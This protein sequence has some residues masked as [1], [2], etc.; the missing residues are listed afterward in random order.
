MNRLAA[1]RRFLNA[2]RY[3]YKTV[4]D[5]D[6]S[7]LLQLGVAVLASERTTHWG[8]VGIGLE[9]RPATLPPTAPNRAWLG[10]VAFAPDYWPSDYLAKLLA[11]AAGCFQPLQL[12][13]EI[14]AQSHTGWLEQALLHAGFVCVDQVVSMVRDVS[15]PSPATATPCQLRSALPTDLADVAWLDTA[16][17]TP[18]WHFSEQQLWE[19]LLRGRMQLA[20]YE[21]RL[22]G[23]SALLTNNKSEAQLARLAVHPAMQRRG[24]GRQLLADSLDYARQSGFEHLALNTQVD[25]MRS[26]A[27]YRAFDFFFTGNPI[28]I[29]TKIYYQ[30]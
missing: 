24:I 27:L 9:E 6:L 30:S 1:V 23:Y 12:P 17:F 11:T 28:S 29:L 26:Q 21:G 14:M 18:R 16:A 13:L 20:E 7:T 4:A 25:N 15:P 19:L 5:E 22:V 8:F 10:A 2:A 3:S